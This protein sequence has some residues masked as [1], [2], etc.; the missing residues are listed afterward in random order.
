MS[1]SLNVRVHKNFLDTVPSCFSLVLPYKKISTPGHLPGPKFRCS[2]QT[3]GVQF[4][5]PPT[6]SVQPRKARLTVFLR[7]VALGQ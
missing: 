7:E 5:L 6:G 2:L 3:Q 1:L 4:F